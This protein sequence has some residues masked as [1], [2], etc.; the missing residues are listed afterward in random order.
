MMN[1]H[2]NILLPNQ[3]VSPRYLARKTKIVPEIVNKLLMEL[4]FRQLIDVQFIINC[5]NEDTDMIHALAFDSESEL[6]KFMR[7]SDSDKCNQCGSKLIRSKIRVAFVKRD[8]E[9]VQGENYG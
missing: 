5:D 8:F 4:S 7:D 6:L 1:E 3:S 2:L 9:S